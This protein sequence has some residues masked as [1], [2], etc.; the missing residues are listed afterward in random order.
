[1]VVKERDRER[2]CERERHIGPVCLH[3]DFSRQSLGW[4][5]VM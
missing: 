4:C 3:I 5:R 2:V 1:M